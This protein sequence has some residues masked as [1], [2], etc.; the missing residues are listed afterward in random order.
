MSALLLISWSLL[1]IPVPETG[2]ASRYGYPGDPYEPIGQP[3][4]CEAILKHRW[5]LKQWQQVVKQGIAHR[6]LPCG[7]PLLICRTASSQCTRAIVV[8]RGPYGAL[9]RHGHWHARKRLP[10]G[11]RY[12]GIVDLLSP[13]AKKLGIRGIEKVAL[14]A[15]P[16]P[17][18]WVFAVLRK[19]LCG[20]VRSHVSWLIASYRHN[21]N[22]V[23]DR[24]QRIR[25]E[26]EVHRSL[27]RRFFQRVL[28]AFLN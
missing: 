23:I 22:W 18:S 14:W 15:S 24:L 3:Y 25:A 1:Q 16:Q 2:L 7:T 28:R 5:G 21:R 6:S 13:V 17:R 26:V 19:W 4:A 20:Q 11:E 8:D 9:D 10:A 12:R 27:K